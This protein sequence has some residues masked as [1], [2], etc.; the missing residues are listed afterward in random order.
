MRQHNMY[1]GGRDYIGS[2]HMGLISQS[3]IGQF[4]YHNNALRVGFMGNMLRIVFYFGSEGDNHRDSSPLNLQAI[5]PNL[6]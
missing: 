5:S 4:V 2:N 3:F 6:L 1:I